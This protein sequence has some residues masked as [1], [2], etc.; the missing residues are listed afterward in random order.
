MTLPVRIKFDELPKHALPRSSTARFTEHWQKSVGDEGFLEGI[1]DRWRNASSMT[2]ADAAHQV[3]LFAEA[4]N[5]PAGPGPEVPVPNGA[6]E[7]RG[8][9]LREPVAPA[10]ELPRR[11]ISIRREVQTT[12]PTTPSPA[13]PGNALRAIRDRLQQR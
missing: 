9:R 1:V 11:D 13:Q 10:G 7:D 2:A 8:V 6:N 12:P 3:A 5:L 4:M